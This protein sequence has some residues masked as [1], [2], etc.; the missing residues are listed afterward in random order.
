MKYLLIAAGVALLIF[1]AISAAYIRLFVSIVP[2]VT[3]VAATVFEGREV[4]T[5]VDIL[6]GVPP[7]AAGYTLVLGDLVTGSG[8][9]IL[10]DPAEIEAARAALWY[11]ETRREGGLLSSPTERARARR[12]VATLIR[13]GAA[14]RIFTCP[15]DEC[16]GWFG[17]S[18]HEG[19]RRS[20]FAAI[21]E[22]ATP[23]DSAPGSAPGSPVEHM[24]GYYDNY[25][26]YRAAHAAISADPTRWFAEPGAQRLAP[27][28]E[29]LAQIDI[30]LPAELLTRN[31]DQANFDDEQAA[32][33]ALEALGRSWLGE[34]QGEVRVRKSWPMDIPILSGPGFD[35]EG[36]LRAL[37]GYSYRQRS[38]T[39][40]MAP[41][42]LDAV[43]ARIDLGGFTPPDLLMLEDALLK[44]VAAAGY[45]TACLPG[46][47][48]VGSGRISHAADLF[49]PAAPGW[50]I[51]SWRLLDPAP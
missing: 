31:A 23:P 29:R 12:E 47:A 44:A 24:T 46:C 37:P 4:E 34:M 16:G 41:A 20:G 48:R 19:A 10:R 40:E 30:S 26:S 49:M 11:L 3:D 7:G 25:D 35:K 15:T 38:I 28:E 51:E 45:D 17:L 8:A 42:D 33:A 43:A 27:R 6:E 32:E 22:A 9:R 2:D 39:L 14:I 36:R 13:D 5:R 18:D 21:R 1:A 50:Q